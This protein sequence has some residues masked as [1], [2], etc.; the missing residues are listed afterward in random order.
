MSEEHKESE[1]RHSK[2]PPLHE[3][4]KP[5]PRPAQSLNQAIRQELRYVD[6]AVATPFRAVRRTLAR[7][8]HN[9]LAESLDELV[10]AMEGM[11]RLPLKVMQAAFGD[12]S[13]SGRKVEGTKSS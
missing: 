12:S 10:W 2:A 11:T 9:A 3:R 5:E 4:E 6:T 13:E 1:T 7:G 8:K